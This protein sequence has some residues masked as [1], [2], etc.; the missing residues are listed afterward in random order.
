MRENGPGIRQHGKGAA[1]SAGAIRIAFC[2]STA[3]LAKKPDA[4]GRTMPLTRTRLIG[5]V[6][7]VAAVLP[8]NALSW[9]DHGHRIVALVAANY[10]SPKAR[11]GVADLIGDSSL[12]E[13]A[14][15]ADEY[16]LSHPDTKP[17]HF[18]DIPK[19]ASNYDAARDCSGGDCV[20]A[21]L[22]KYK[23]VL[24]DSNQSKNDRL[25]ALRFIVHFVGDMHQPLHC[26]DNNDRGGNNIKVVFLGRRSNLHAVWDTGII[27]E[28]GLEEA[29]FAD[30]LIST[31]TDEKV[32][33]AQQGTFV[34][35]ALQ[36]HKV[37]VS[38]AYR[39]PPANGKSA[40]VLGQNYYNANWAAV[41]RQLTVAGLRLAK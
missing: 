16:P 24:G 37:A 40:R 29:E 23:T 4:K 1:V 31:I 13:M 14:T 34:D 6:I 30:E 35:W 32:R 8:M 2:C 7:C 33:Q 28:A 36:A 9:G 17:W 15:W 12:A 25:M 27:E 26:A 18:V 22:D 38:N 11:Q 39:L 19:A 5:A 21:A 41:D 10:L 20:I 3:S